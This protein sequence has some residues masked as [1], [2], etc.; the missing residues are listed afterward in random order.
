[1]HN[2]MMAL[3]KTNFNLTSYLKEDQNLESSG[4]IIQKI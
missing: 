3:A 4:N 2:A 1:M